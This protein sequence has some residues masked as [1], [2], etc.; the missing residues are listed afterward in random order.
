MIWK[1]EFGE[2]NV[3]YDVDWGQN[4]I[5]AVGGLLKELHLRKFDKAS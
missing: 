5:L 3:I 1:E 2:K 4:G